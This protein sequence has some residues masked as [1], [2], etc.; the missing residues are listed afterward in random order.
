M[1]ADER[2]RRLPE[3]TNAGLEATV[4]VT[5]F[6]EYN[7]A[8]DGSVALERPLTLYLDKRELVT[9]MTLGNYPE[10]LI[11]GWLRNQSAAITT[12][13]G[14][15]GLEDKLSHRT[16]TTGCGQGTVFGDLMESLDEVPA[17]PQPLKQSTIYGLL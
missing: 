16:V 17:R 12:Y 10:W 3:L 15:D 8:V 6:N 11:L 5:S 4:G 14:V 13:D 2:E 7:E 9:L 1:P